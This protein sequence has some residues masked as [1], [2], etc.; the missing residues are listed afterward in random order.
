MGIEGLNVKKGD[1][2]RLLDTDDPSV[3]GIKIN[4]V[5]LV[6]P[7]KKKGDTGTVVDVTFAIDSWQI[8]VDWDDGS[9]FA[10]L[11]GIDKFEVI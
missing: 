5:S 1:R 11:Y 3:V 8:W 7:W 4:D 9:H 2:I 6:K 10:L